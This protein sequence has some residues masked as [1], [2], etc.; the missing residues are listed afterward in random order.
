MEIL[1]N[2]GN[3]KIHTFTSPGTFCVST[4]SSVSAENTVGYLVLA[5]G[6]AD[7]DWE[8]VDTQNVPGLVKV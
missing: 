1:A 2:D 4:V 7:R 3:F 6:V 5:G 8:T